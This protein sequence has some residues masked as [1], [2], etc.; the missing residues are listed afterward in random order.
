MWAVI[1]VCQNVELKKKT[2]ERQ[3]SI[4]T[5]TLSCINKLSRTII[6]HFSDIFLQCLLLLKTNFLSTSETTKSFTTPKLIEKVFFTIY[7]SQKKKKNPYAENIDACWALFL[8]RLSP[9]CQN[10]TAWRVLD[11]T[12]YQDGLQIIASC[13]IPF[14]CGKLLRSKKKPQNLRTCTCHFIQCPYL[15][16]N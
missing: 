16:K 10:T 1:I 15:R 3:L 7:P 4:H 12:Q 9:V 5:C 2:R 6:S 13:E 14:L 11:T 8:H